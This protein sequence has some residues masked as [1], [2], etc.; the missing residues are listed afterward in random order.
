M[1]VIIA[2]DIKNFS[3]GIYIFV[4]NMKTRSLNNFEEKI[5]YY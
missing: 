3:P 1:E 4:M 2:K 5:E